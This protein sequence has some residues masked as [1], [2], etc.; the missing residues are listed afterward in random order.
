M[1]RFISL[2]RRFHSDENGAFA[3]I[4]ATMAIVVLALGGA[5]V[6]FVTL[7]QA[8]NRAQ[9]ALDAATL[10]LQRD[11]NSLST[12]EITSAA[13]DLMVERIGNDQVTAKITNTV[14]NTEQGSL[15]FEAVVEVPTMFVSLVGV[16]KIDAGLASEATRGSVNLEFSVAVD[17]TGS[18]NDNI[19][20][21]TNGGAQQT[22]VAALKAAL[23]VLIDIV[24]QTEQTPT[25]SKMAIVPYSMGVNVGTY[26]E[27]IRGPV[28]APTPISKVAWADG[29]A[30]AITA[31]TKARPVVI[32]STSHGFVDGDR[33]YVNGVKGMTSINNSIF[34]VKRVNASSYQLLSDDGT[35]LDGRNFDAYTSSGTATKCLT[36][37]CELV[38]T[39]AS[40]GLKNGDNVYLS[41]A[42]GMNNYS[43]S[44]QGSSFNNNT[45]GDTSDRFL[46]WPVDGVTVSSFVLPGTTRTNERDYGSYISG[47]S[48]ACV[49]AG[50]EYYYYENMHG[51]YR[52]QQIS[53]CVTERSTNPFNDVPASTTLLGRNYPSSGNPCLTNTI[54]PLTD[55]KAALHNIANNLQAGGSTAGHTGVAWAW[56]LISSKFQGPWPAASQPA[57][58]DKPN[59]LKAVVIMTDGEFNS[60]YCNGVISQSSTSGSGDTNNQIKCNAPNGSSYSQA[61]KLCAEMNRLNES[62]GPSANIRVYTV[63]FDVVDSQSARDLMKNCASDPS[64]A[65]EAA[66]GADLAAVFADIGQNLALLRLTQ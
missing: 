32:T 34:R 22:K 23:N 16:P 21:S 66:T 39:S 40:H 35:S 9:L 8:R 31:A 45:N 25:Y 27:S 29:S 41:G 55:N 26:A 47:G 65:Y 7:Q 13:E 19:K 20:V 64:M 62:D 17:L 1:T 44:N 60:V 59:V 58:A 36:N 38:V 5:A 28:K 30:K 3:I 63:G 52:R 37:K 33:I 42:K 18:M 11:I 50:C 4:F 51:A 10:A 53:T 14:I 54:V 61:Q 56:Y 2:I 46:V 12:A 6:D 24:V 49:L 57:P 43:S 48:A 15:K